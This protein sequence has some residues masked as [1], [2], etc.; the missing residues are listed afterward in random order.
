MCGHTTIIHSRVGPVQQG[1]PDRQTD[2][3][4]MHRHRNALSKSTGAERQQNLCIAPFFVTKTMLSSS[5]LKK[6]IDDFTLRCLT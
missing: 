1:Q 6:M 2:S 3:L 5:V 4:Q